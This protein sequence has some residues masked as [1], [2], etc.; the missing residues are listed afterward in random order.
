M[1]KEVILIVGLTIPVLAVFVGIILLGV[2]FYRSCMTSADRRIQNLIA[3]FSSD[4]N[5]G[6]TVRIQLQ[7]HYGFLN[8]VRIYQVDTPVQL[9]NA[10]PFLKALVRFNLRWGLL[11]LGGLFV[12]FIA[13]S[14]YAREK[15][16]IRMVMEKTQQSA[17]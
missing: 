13:W 9:D 3:A 2:K 1:D 10:I 15:K 8:S 14:E 7:A 5:Q 6:Q 16:K 11:G 4:E 17:R 12:P